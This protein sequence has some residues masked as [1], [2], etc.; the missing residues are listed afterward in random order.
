MSAAITRAFAGSRVLVTGHTGFKGSWLSLWLHDLGAG[1]TGFA[2]DP[3]TTPCLFDALALVRLVDDRRGDVRDAEA[4]LRAIG[5][6]NPDIIFHLAAQPLVRLSYQ[7][8]R[9]T[10][11]TNVMGVVNLLEAVRRA[12]RPV[13]VIVVTSDKCY[14]PAPEPRRHREDEPLGGHDPYSA[15]KGA[16]ELVVDAYRRSFFAPADISRHGV[17]L[18]SVRAGNV[19]GGGDWAA[20]RL[21]PDLVRAQEQGVPLQVRNPSAVRPWQ[22]VFDALSGY[23]ALGAELL[24]NRA[25]GYCGAFNFGPE[26][27]DFLDVRQLAEWM[28]S[29]WG[30]GAWERASENDP[31]PEA[32]HLGLAIDKA[33]QALAWRPVW[34]VARAVTETARWYRAHRQHG[35]DSEALLRLSRAQLADYVADARAQD[36]GWAGAHS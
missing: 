1:V 23:L 5:Q 24:G 3:P 6:S 31:P 4:L 11:E 34:D 36:A 30:E 26:P 17:A 25:A 14:A 2:L 21:V 32:P 13:A 35:G 18:A 10:F 19:I 8:P 29:V 27:E 12:H 15:S 16:A 28:I 9:E 33:R 22:H 7:E 20:D